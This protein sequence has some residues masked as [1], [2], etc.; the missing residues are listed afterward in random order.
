MG[1]TSSFDM[2]LSDVYLDS[3][4]EKD[5]ELDASGYYVLMELIN[6]NGDD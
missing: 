1:L 4:A 3:L 2:F 5:K 6:L